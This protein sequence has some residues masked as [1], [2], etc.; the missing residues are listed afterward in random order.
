[1]GIWR[2]LRGTVYVEMI[3][4]DLAGVLSEINGAGI[5]LRNVKYKGDITA[6]AEIIR[7]DLAH[8]AK[9][10]EGRGGK[11]RICEKKGLYWSLRKLI[12]RPVLCIGAVIILLAAIMLPGRI[13]FVKVEG[14]TSI[15]KKLILEKAETCGIGFGAVRRHVR[16]EKMK[17]ALLSAIPELQWA[18]INTSGCVATISVKEKSITDVNQD[19]KTVVSNIVALRDGIIRDFTVLQGDGVCQ[20][21]QAVRKGQVLISGYTD[22]GLTIKA[23]QAK[24]EIYAQTLRKLEMVTPVSTGIRGDA[25]YQKTRYTLRIGKKLIKLYKDSGISDAS[26]VKM[27]SEE[28][29]TLPGGFR[30]PVALIQETQIVYDVQAVTETQA[31]NYTWLESAASAYLQEQ[32]IA[33]KILN[34]DISLSMDEGYCSILGSYACTEMIGKEISEEILQ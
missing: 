8:V 26:C 25:S 32:M 31:D 34:A 4:A 11:I 33:G 20:V 22:V 3:C 19:K 16:S 7:R 12:H 23:T 10:I 5:V 27:Y 15:P 21:G 30:L 29:L 1:M 14:N 2:S 18:G 9:L 17:N 28:Y 24:G 13:F 6:G